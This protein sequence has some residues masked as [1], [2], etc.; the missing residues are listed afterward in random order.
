MTLKNYLNKER[1]SV[2][3][4]A[5]AIS[6]NQHTVNKWVYTDVVPRKGDVVK[7]YTFTKGQVQPNDFYGIST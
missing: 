2:A 1:Y 4:F 6:V 7:V 3:K 5:N